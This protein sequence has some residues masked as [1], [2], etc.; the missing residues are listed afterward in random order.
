MSATSRLPRERSIRKRCPSGVT[1]KVVTRC[2][3]PPV[4]NSTTGFETVRDPPWDVT[5]TA[6]TPPPPRKKISLLLDQTGDSPPPL[7][8][9]NALIPFGK[10]PHEDLVRPD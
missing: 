6:E 9:L 1:S 3:L 2:V 10:R 7:R 5:E 8:H 4:G